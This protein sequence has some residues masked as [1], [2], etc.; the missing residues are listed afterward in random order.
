M[1]VLNHSKI[2]PLISTC[3]ACLVLEGYTKSWVLKWSYLARVGQTKLSLGVYKVVFS[4][5]LSLHV[6]RAFFLRDKLLYVMGLEMVMFS[7]FGTNQVTFGV[8]KVFFSQSSSGAVYVFGFENV[9]FGHE[10]IMTSMVWLMWDN[11]NCP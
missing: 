3:S 8:Y 5:H 4:K 10:A 1:I 9:I 2:R 6:E 7:S 11:P